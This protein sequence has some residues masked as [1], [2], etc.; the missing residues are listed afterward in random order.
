M[1][2]GGIRVRVRV[3][4]SYVSDYFDL[5]KKTVEFKDIPRVIPDV[6]Q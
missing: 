4:V 5:H 3:R 6:G 1:A 2:K